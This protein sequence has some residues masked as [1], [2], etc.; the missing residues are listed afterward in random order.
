M[1]FA[2]ISSPLLADHQ[3]SEFPLKQDLQTGLETFLET[4]VTAQSLD[5]RLRV[6]KLEKELSSLENMSA[7]TPKAQS[8]S[9]QRAGRTSQIY[10]EIIL[11]ALNMG[12]A[13]I[14]SRYARLAAELAYDLDDIELRIYSD[15]A[16]ANLLAIQG[17]LDGAK[18]AILAT[19]ALAER[20]SDAVNVFFADVML[21]FLGPE[22]GNYLEGLS[23]MA[24]GALDLP[25]T[26]RGNRMRMAAYLTMAYTYTGIGEL[27]EQAHYYMLVSELA[28][29][30]GFAYDR[31]SILYNIA[32][33][34]AEQKHNSLAKKYFNGLGAVLK[35]T[36]NKA[37]EYYVLYGLAWLKYDA[38][39]YKGAIGLAHRAL[40]DYTGDPYFN[41]T[42]ND[43]IAISSAKL[44]DAETARLYM[45]KSSAFLQ[46]NPDYK[47]FTTKAQH[48]LATA[49][50]LRAENK[51]DAA[52]DMLNTARLTAARG[53]ARQFRSNIQDLRANL[54]T[55][56]AKQSAEASLK[57]ANIANT[58]LIVIFSLLITLSAALLLFMQRR[59]TKALKKSI[60]EAEVANQTKSEFLANMSHELRTPLN[61]ILGFS[62]MMT[63]KI[64]GELGA[65]QYTEYAAHIHGSGRH[66]LDIINDILDLS[67]VES[68]QLSVS[69][70]DINLP[71]LFEEVRTLLMPRAKDR[72]VNIGIHVDKDVPTIFADWRLMKQILL[73]LLSNGVKFTEAGGRV[74]MIAS[75]DASGKVQIEVN[76]TGIGMTPAE[77][78]LALTPFGQAGTTLTR[79]HEGTGL[80][81]PLVKSLVELH[82]GKLFIRSRKN[83]GTTVKILMPS[84]PKDQDATK[85]TPTTRTTKA[86][87]AKPVAATKPSEA[88]DTADAE[89]G[90]RKGAKNG[91]GNDA[92]NNAGAKR[93]KGPTA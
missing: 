80:G 44:G 12:D 32:S 16:K 74:N 35:Q 50:I 69:P 62:E 43:L 93:P 31:E 70:T 23:Q 67:K 71:A 45:D 61:A 21:A 14:L 59:H 5:A 82:S 13:D 84:T 76:D 52:F 4:L 8:A 39:D 36:G 90:A 87:K 60:I 51:L 47:G 56:L 81:L 79:S 30:T 73:N 64:F 37:G 20:E 6:R 25:N 49:F 11:H 68:G 85:A 18:N 89:N 53:A 63:K 92:R 42:L 78:E 24:Q 19:R 26:D 7:S 9:L 72:G 46:N 55:M 27:R 3:S 58:R 57:E 75:M 22:M 54:E 40:E 34:L 17:N 2:F 15:L 48:Q 77:L 86:T 65:R 41:S 88:T 91:A 28:Q 10:K 83:V 66:L 33:T 29:K 38:D 1:L